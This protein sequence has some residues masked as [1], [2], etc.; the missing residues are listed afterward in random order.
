MRF[1]AF[2]EALDRLEP[3]SPD[4]QALSVGLVVMRAV[5]GIMHGITAPP[6]W[7]TIEAVQALDSTTFLERPVLSRLVDL[8]LQQ[9]PYMQIVVELGG[10]L[11]SYGRFLQGRSRWALAVPVF[12]LAALAARDAEEQELEFQARLMAAFSIRMWRDFDAALGRYA[13]L[14]RL[15]KVRSNVRFALEARLGAVK[16]LLDRGNVP[17]AKR[18]LDVIR[19]RAKAA[20]ERGVLG[21]TYIELAR[22]HGMRHQYEE[23]IR[24]SYAAL[25]LAED[26]RDRDRIAINMGLAY[27]ELRRNDLA[28]AVLLTVSETAQ[29]PEQRCIATL[30]LANVAVDDHNG[31]AAGAYL[32][33]L[34][35]QSLPPVLLAELHEVEGRWAQACGNRNGA[36][37]AYEAMRQVSEAAQLAELVLRADAA[38]AGLEHTPAR[39]G[40]STAPNV[41]LARI[42]METRQLLL[43]R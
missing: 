20:N 39:R 40:L 37:Q 16:V 23:S 12:D 22:V 33:R 34:R 15:A 21:K 32:T 11:M 38:L 1:A 28:R 10:P 13:E 19:H 27:R 31:P 14:Y 43:V 29:E 36:E 41:R 25:Q 2:F 42:A 9:R 17:K 5:A 7:A 26:S 4:W 8:L 30:A 3:S 6:R 35:A 18:H 24:A